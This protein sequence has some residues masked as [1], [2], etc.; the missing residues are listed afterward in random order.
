MSGTVFQSMMATIDGQTVRISA[1][2]AIG[3]SMMPSR[4]RFR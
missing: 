4:I 1:K 2:K 3:W